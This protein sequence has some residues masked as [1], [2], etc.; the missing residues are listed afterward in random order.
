MDVI[1]EKIKTYT[2]FL[3]ESTNS[4]NFPLLKQ[5]ILKYKNVESSKVSV[6][7]L[8]YVFM[9]TK[10]FIFYLFLYFYMLSTFY[11]FSLRFAPN[12]SNSLSS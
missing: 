8:K 12:C 7:I 9:A 5:E 3:N 10:Y 6:K 2:N 1:L 11:F 4:D